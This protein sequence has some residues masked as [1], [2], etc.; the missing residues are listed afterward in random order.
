MANT[1]TFYTHPQSRG[2]MVHWLLEEQY[3]ARW[4]TRPALQR[5]LAGAKP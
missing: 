2:R 3:I 4:A 1:V 5:V